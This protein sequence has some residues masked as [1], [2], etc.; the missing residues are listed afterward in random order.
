MSRGPGVVPE[1]GSTSFMGEEG[2]ARASVRRARVYMTPTTLA[3]QD[4]HLD[5]LRAVLA[6][7]RVMPSPGAPAVPPTPVQAWAELLEA[8]ASC[9]HLAAVLDA[10][11]PSSLSAPSISRPRTG[12]VGGL[13]RRVGKE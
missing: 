9:L 5:C 2:R 3:D 7:P 11:P 4:A 10:S 8:A 1:N 6:D 12:S 13:P